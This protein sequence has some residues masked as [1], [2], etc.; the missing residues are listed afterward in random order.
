MNTIIGLVVVGNFEQGTPSSVGW[1]KHYVPTLI[2]LKLTGLL[3]SIKMLLLGR[4]KY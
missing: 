4:V 2:F 1:C 3:F